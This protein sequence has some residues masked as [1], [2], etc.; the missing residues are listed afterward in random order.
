LHLI[1]NN[2]IGFT[3]LPSAARSTRYA[4]DLAKGFE[5]PVVHVNADDP[6]AC[7]SV[8]RLAHA[9]RERFHKDFVIDLV[10]YRRWG[11]NEGDEPAFTQPKMYEVIRSLPTVREQWAARLV[12][13]GV[14]TQEEADAMLQSVLDELARIQER[15]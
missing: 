15:L 12:A 7:L 3:T 10:G 6:E 8:A 1:A 14:V 11:H 13:E 4:S 9:Y 2:Q 5:L